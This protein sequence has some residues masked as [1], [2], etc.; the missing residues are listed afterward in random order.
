MT[1]VLVN[2]LLDWLSWVIGSGL[3]V[4]L[5]GDLRRFDL[6]RLVDLAV[7]LVLVI[8]LF[9]GLGVGQWFVGLVELGDWFVI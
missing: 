9:G 3:G 4:G 5:F 1:W 2:G 6:C 7:G 8:G